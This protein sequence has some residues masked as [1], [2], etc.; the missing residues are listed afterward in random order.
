MTCSGSVKVK[1][2][3]TPPRTKCFRRVKG[4]G[5][6]EAL[7]NRSS[8]PSPSRPSRGVLASLLVRGK[9][10]ISAGSPFGVCW[11]YSVR[12]SQLSLSWVL[13]S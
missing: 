10:L 8:C 7:L 4:Y 1:K 6:A 5:T 12:S 13:T 3:G 2:K 9:H 11:R